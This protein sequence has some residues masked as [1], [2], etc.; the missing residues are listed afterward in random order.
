MSGF[1]I[2]PLQEADRPWAAGVLTEAWGAPR[3]VTR[4]RVHQGDL[5]ALRF[6]QK[7]GWTLA[8]L[9]P[10]VLAESRRLKPE[11]PLVGLGGIP[12]ATRSSWSWC[13]SLGT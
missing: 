5:P 10:N 3:I 7:R 6:Y 4:G 2:R 13:C 11:I 12:C 9:Y 8:A 1:E